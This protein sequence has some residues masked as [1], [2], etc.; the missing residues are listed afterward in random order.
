MVL[1]CVER[2]KAWRLLQSKAGIDNREYRA[3]RALLARLA[4]GELT[5]DDLLKGGAMLLKEEVTKLA[6]S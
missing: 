3:Q 4:K 6:A 5:R 1:L 2:R